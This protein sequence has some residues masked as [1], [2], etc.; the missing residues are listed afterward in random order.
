VL[1]S[2]DNYDFT[3]T[4]ITSL[5]KNRSSAAEA[6]AATPVATPKPRK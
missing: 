6:P 1:Y 3:D 4:V 2:R 5:N